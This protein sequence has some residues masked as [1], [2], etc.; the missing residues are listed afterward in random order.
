[1]PMLWW[2]AGL[3]FYSFAAPSS[4]MGVAVTFAHAGFL[5]GTLTCLVVYGASALGA[6]LFVDLLAACPGAKMFSDVGRVTLGRTGERIGLVL[7][8]ANFVL[9]LPVALLTTAQAL[10]DALQPSGTMC[11]NY[12]VF[13]VA[14]VCFST[15]QVRDLSNSSAL[16]IVALVASLAIAV[17]QVA[18][19]ASYPADEVEP[20]QWFGNPDDGT[21]A[22]S[23][24][25][26][27]GLTTCAWSY[28]PSILTVELAH[29]IGAPPQCAPP[30][31]ARSYTRAE[32]PTTRREHT[33]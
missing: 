26:A 21:T 2:Q 25:L 17:L 33:L 5:G 24:R 7:Q 9:Y 18:I 3:I 12:F 11:T 22:G 30:G 29:A 31:C 8:M 15:T 14:L 28:V 32:R 23:V 13:F 4:I 20:T 19:A 16:A 10:Q 27:L 6:L 1:M